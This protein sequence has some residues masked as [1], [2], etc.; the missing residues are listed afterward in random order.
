MENSHDGNFMV[1][2]LGGEEVVGDG[3]DVTLAFGGNV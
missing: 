1:D 2:V 3:G